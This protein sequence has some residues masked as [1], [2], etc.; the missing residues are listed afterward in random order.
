MRIWCTLCHNMSKDY[1][2][3]RVAHY[4]MDHNL[5]QSNNTNAKKTEIITN[6]LLHRIHGCSLKHPQKNVKYDLTQTIIQPS[7]LPVNDV[8]TWNKYSTKPIQVH[9]SLHRKCHHTISINFKMTNLPHKSKTNNTVS[10]IR[11]TE[12]FRMI[13]EIYVWNYSDT[14]MYLL[15]HTEINNAGDTR[16][17][18]WY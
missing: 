11:R 18:I 5:G 4:R 7:G 10:Q 1:L 14:S 6:A 12:R 17:D 15:T 13:K 8:S 16:D 3:V 2:Y 9:W